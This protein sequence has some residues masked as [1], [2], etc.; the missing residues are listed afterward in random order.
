MKS[1][2]RT[3]RPLALAVAALV[4]LPLALSGCGSTTAASSSETA[5]ELS[6]MD[7]YNNEPDKSF[8]GDALSKCGT[9]LG[10]TVKRET[11]PGKSLIS[12]VLQQSSSKTL[13]DVLMLDNPDL[14]QIAAT[15][16]L[17]PLADFKVSTENFAEGVLS[18]GTYKDKVYGL[19]PTV[20]TIALFYNKD[21][22]AAAGVTPPTTWEEL[23]AASAKLT[24]GDQYGLAFNANPTYEGT[25]QFLPV[26]WSNGGD[27]KKI[28]TKETE[29]ALQLWTDLVKSGSV[30]SS[31]LNWTQADVK[32]QFLAGKA[33]MMVNGPWQIPAL[34]KQPT[35]QYGV[36]KIPVREAGQTS[37]AP[38]GGEVWTVPQTGNK[39]RQ[40]KAAEMVA[41]LNSDENQL[42][43]ATARNT[44][45]SKTTLSDKFA[46]DNPKLATFTELIKTARARTGQL[47]EEWPAQATKIYTAIQTSLTGNASPADALKQAQGQ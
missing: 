14:Q 11:V 47:G 45:P 1:A 23:K 21:I 44:I 40:A 2:Q 12:K 28:D 37:V 7:Y 39:A 3:Y 17:A 8:I 5:T 34:D 22:L 30:S 35:L 27:E 16:A 13:P 31:A 33:A 29:Q 9:Q 4:G 19:A 46:S 20:N 25:W 38:L 26:M 24:A 36:V 18:A 41:C 42:A 10:V 15:G 43:M 6:V 32:D